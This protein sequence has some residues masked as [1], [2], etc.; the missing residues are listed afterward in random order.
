MKEEKKENKPFT[1]ICSEIIGCMHNESM[2]F[3][4]E[5]SEN[6][7][8][9]TV[10]YRFF[11][12]CAMLFTIFLW[13]LFVVFAMSMSKITKCSVCYVKIEYGVAVKDVEVFC[14][15]TTTTTSPITQKQAKP[16]YQ[17]LACKTEGKRRV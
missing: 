10:V 5:F 15:H 14:N 1:W 17:N 12:Y 4:V 13:N 16:I 8:F 6:T 7:S 3:V 2:D 11:D 9:D